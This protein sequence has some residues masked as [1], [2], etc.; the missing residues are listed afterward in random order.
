MMSA[1]RSPDR[2]VQK[3][4]SNKASNN[5]IGFIKGSAN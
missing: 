2:I 4:I 1:Q 5:Q 3:N